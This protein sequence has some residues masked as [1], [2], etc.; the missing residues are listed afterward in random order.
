MKKKVFLCG[1]MRGVSREISLGWRILATKYLSKNFEVVHAMR[2]R[3]E[4]ETFTDSRAAVI[5]DI[6]DIKNT[7]IMLVNDTIEDCGMIGTSMEVFL[8]HQLD[9]P[10]IVFGHA[11]D[12]DYWLNY[13]IHLR[14]D[15]LE[16]ACKVLKKMF[17]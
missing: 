1:P 11:H 5:R 8:A 9:K 16:E 3:E 2:G 13:H 15:N 14:T 17:I 6:N 4:K 10:I 12:K 7:D